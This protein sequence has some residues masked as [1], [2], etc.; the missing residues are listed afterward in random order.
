M[1]KP[2]HYEWEYVYGYPC[3]E[4]PHNFTPDMESCTP[5]EIRFW[6][7]AKRKWLHGK[8]NVRG[9]RSGWISP[10]VHVTATSWGIGTNAIR[11]KVKGK[12]NRLKRWLVETRPDCGKKKKLAKKKKGLSW[13]AKDMEQRHPPIPPN[14]EYFQ[15]GWFELS[16]TQCVRVFDPGEHA[17]G[18]IAA[19]A[20]AAW[21]DEMQRISK[22]ELRA[23]PGEIRNA[24]ENAELWRVWG[25]S[26]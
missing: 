4:N 10:G 19:V 24:Y 11:V 23:E 5:K 8:R 6:R 13:K 17:R 26:K 22:L 18:I 14:C 25:I 9:A 15:D 7:N 2:W 20:R 12:A 21:L 3:V 16:H 1:K